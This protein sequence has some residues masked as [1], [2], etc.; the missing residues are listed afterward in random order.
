M[1][2]AI[3]AVSLVMALG[4]LACDKSGADTQ[5][6]VNEAQDKANKEIGRANAQANEAQN[7]ADR[8]IA[9][10]LADFQATRED[11]RHK[12]QSDL[13]SLDKDIAD[14]D[15]RVRTGSTKAESDLQAKLQAKL[16]SIHA[17]RDAFANDFRSID[18]ASAAS[19]DAFKTRLDKEWSDLKSAVDK[20]S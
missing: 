6:Q 4:P 8:K 19:F 15:A 12:V 13:D 16:P 2:R 9:A 7:E 1:N 14:L 18:S 20:A 17:Q 5:A 10:A 11:Y 3:V